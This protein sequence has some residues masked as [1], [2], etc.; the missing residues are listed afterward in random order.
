[1]GHRLSVVQVSD[2]VRCHCPLTNSGLVMDL[3]R[4]EILDFDVGP[5]VSPVMLLCRSASL[6]QEGS[7]FLSLLIAGNREDLALAPP[8]CHPSCSLSS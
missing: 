3:I 4:F 2:L 8:T 5:L 6:L 7:V 1:M